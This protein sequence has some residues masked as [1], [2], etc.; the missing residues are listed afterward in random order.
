MDQSWDLQKAGAAANLAWQGR[1]KRS[2]EFSQREGHGLTEG[3]IK[4]LGREAG[5]LPRLLPSFDVSCAA[6]RTQTPRREGADAEAAAGGA[7]AAGPGSG[8]GG[9]QEEGGHD[10]P[11][12]SLLG[13]GPHRQAR[14]RPGGAEGLART[15]CRSYC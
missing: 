9:D 2:R 6:A 13:K 3:C 4:E 14:L 12:E 10:G 15:V 11:G 7:S 1:V 5:S 8:P